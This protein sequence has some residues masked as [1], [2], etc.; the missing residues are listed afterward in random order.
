M[1]KVLVLVHGMGDHLP[2]WSVDVADKLDALLA[3]YPPFD[4]E[5]R[6]FRNRVAIEEICYDAVFDRFIQTWGREGTRLSQFATDHGIAL[7][8]T[9][10]QIIA[11]QLPQDVSNFVWETLLD[12]VLYRGSSL[13]RDRVREIGRAHV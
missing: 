1:S 3:Q 7:N 10:T 8:G 13:V 12:P 5:D 9:L 6:P 2:G 4:Q 11:G